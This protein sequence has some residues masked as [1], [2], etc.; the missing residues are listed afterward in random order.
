MNTAL[1]P[2][3][4]IIDLCGRQIRE[5]VAAQHGVGRYQIEWNLRD[6]TGERVPTG[7]YW[8]SIRNE[9]HHLERRL[10]IMPTQ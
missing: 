10:L 2:H 7:I 8:L 1:K 5:L 6:H 4:A 3:A 9:R